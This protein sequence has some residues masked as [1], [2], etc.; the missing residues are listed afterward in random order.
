MD[1]QP[2]T[3]RVRVYDKNY[4][5]LR[6]RPYVAVLDFSPGPGLRATQGQLD[7][8][9][10]SLAYAA[11]ARGPR[12]LDFHLVVCDAEDGVTVCHWPATS[13]VADR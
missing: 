6:D 9:V 2:R 13:W 11:G 12:T 5:V 8:L 7:S 3:F 4:E 1:L 10:T